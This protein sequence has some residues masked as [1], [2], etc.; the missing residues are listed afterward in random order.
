MAG[1]LATVLN[2]EMT[3]MK[4][5]SLLKS[6]M[7]KWACITEK[8]LSLVFLYGRELTFMYLTHFTNQIFWIFKSS[9]LKSVRDENLEL[10]M[11]WDNR[12]DSF[13][14]FKF[15]LSSPNFPSFRCLVPSC[16]LM[17]VDFPLSVCVCVCVCCLVAKLCPT[18]LLLHGLWPRQVLCPWNFPGKNTGLGCKF[19]LQGIF[20][21]RGSNPH[22]LL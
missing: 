22:L 7:M 8:Y 19:L 2:H 13:F 11:L 18:L 20:P 1:T 4:E 6:K 9:C 10:Q 14:C 3:L 15:S 12:P 21:S 16:G 17:V 5:A